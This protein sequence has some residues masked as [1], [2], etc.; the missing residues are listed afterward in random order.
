MIK[1]ITSVNLP[2]YAVI[3]NAT[4]EWNFMGDRT[5]TVSMKIDGARELSF[6]GTDNKPWTIK[7]RGETYFMPLRDPQGKKSI[8]SAQSVVDLTFYHEAIYDLK[9]YYF[10][11][12]ATAGSS[13]VVNKYENSIGWNISQ[14]VSA[15]NQV[16]SY[17]FGSGSEQKIYMELVP[18][19]VSDE[20]KFVSISHNYI[21]E[22]LQNVYDTYGYTWAISFENNKYVIKVGAAEPELSHVF[23]YGYDGGLTSVER[24]LQNDNIR[25]IILGRGTD[26]NIPAYYFKKKATGSTSTFPDD[27]DYCE[28]LANIDM[29]QL[30]GYTFREYVRGWN[31]GRHSRGTRPAE[32]SEEWTAGY[33]AGSDANG[34]FDPIEYVKS[35]ESISK[36][37]ELWGIQDDNEEVY[38]SIQGVSV[39][40]LGRIDEI[41]GYNNETPDSIDDV[42]KTEAT[43]ETLN[44]AMKAGLLISSPYDIGFHETISDTFEVQEG[45]IAS[46]TDTLKAEFGIIEY[47][48]LKWVSQDEK[49]R[50]A[51]WI[52]SA[53]RVYYRVYNINT[54][55][56]LVE[57]DSEYNPQFIPEGSWE[58]HFY[59]N[60]TLSQPLGE[61]VIPAYQFR[62]VHKDIVL[63]RVADGVSSLDTFDIWVKNIWETNRNSYSSDTEYVEAVWGAIL[64]D[65]AGNEA[66][67]TFTSGNLS[68]S[69]DYEFLIPAPIG[70]FIHYDTSKT[71]NGVNSEWRITLE[72]S[73]A[74]YQADKKFIPRQGIAANAGDKFIFTGIDV[75]HSYVLNAEKRL[76]EEK[77]KVLDENKDIDPQWVV[78]FDKVRINTLET[79]ETYTLFSMLN[80]GKKIKLYDSRFMS[81]DNKSL[82]IESMTIRWQDDSVM[83]PEVEVT[84]SHEVR[85]V[86]SAIDEIRSDVRYI[87]ST[88]VDQSDATSIARAVS[89]RTAVQ[90]VGRATASSSSPTEF[91]SIVKSA[92]FEQGKVGGSGWAVYSDP[93]GNA[94]LE[95]DKVIARRGVSTNDFVINQ[96]RH[97]GG[98]EVLSAASIQI[99]RVDIQ[100]DIIRCWFDN[101]SGSMRNFF[102]ADDIAFSQTFDG[103]NNTARVYKYIVSSATENYVDLSLTDAHYGDDTPVPG[104]TLIQYGNISDAS[105]QYVIIRNASNGGYERMLMG[106]NSVTAT[107]TEY[108]FAGQS[109]G[110]KSRWYVGDSARSIEYAWSETL[111]KY[112]LR[113]SGDVYVGS[114]SI[115]IS[116]L[117]YLAQSLSSD[118]GQGL[119]L[120]NQIAVYSNDA[121]PVVKGGISG[122]YDSTS[123]GGGIAAWFGGEKKSEGDNKASILFRFDGTGYVAGGNLSWDAEG[124]VTIAGNTTIGSGGETIGSIAGDYVSKTKDEEVGGAKTF[125]EDTLFKGGI[126]SE[127]TIVGA[128]GVA[129]GG[130]ADLSI[131]ETGGGGGSSLEVIAY[132]DLSTDSEVETQVATAY[133]VARLKEDIGMNVIEEFNPE[134]SYKRGDVVKRNGKGYRFNTDKNSGAWD[135][136]YCDVLRYAAL[137]KPLSI[138][139]D[140]INNLN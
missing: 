87:E 34:K 136:S 84:L 4:V 109:S 1:E 101:V 27:P 25:N 126:V 57:N 40:G 62:V 16:L 105:R 68:R 26:K 107:G 15:F 81:G 3:N 108:Y 127:K 133:S 118:S 48:T 31:F 36:Y 130:I 102:I 37:G 64:G 135:P 9:R 71:L 32:P 5:I 123:Q 122:I 76:D 41:V 54:N 56:Y 99:T 53:E 95:V 46:F 112:I 30:H 80:A 138:K 24:Q 58:I 119:I 6:I 73:R 88:S 91:S 23:S 42:A 59:D 50:E 120:S 128:E 103:N 79:G 55:T 86:K 20:S 92:F 7:Y 100:S 104:D 75:P 33:T 97:S 18:S 72:K 132:N 14:F 35:D 61:H 45:F 93:D 140:F 43:M 113:I 70:R 98:V 116:D 29:S 65:K 139:K 114:E 137:A 39:Q 115:N 28:E 22:T 89:A 2:S 134:L 19:Q 69:S 90:A 106:L 96:T 38:P 10:F 125:L 63:S 47:G 8:D 13:I 78:A 66:K 51:G 67:V 60:V 21:W 121:T 124:K 131:H 12:P 44:E 82:I 129:A 85:T 74:E 52:V 94:T 11:E 83:L 77:R 17:Y 111:G 49:R 110:S 117:T